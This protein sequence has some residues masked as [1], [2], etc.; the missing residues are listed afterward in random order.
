M[1][2]IFDNRYHIDKITLLVIKMLIK[3][4]EIL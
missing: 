4:G 1:Q 3:K 2:Q